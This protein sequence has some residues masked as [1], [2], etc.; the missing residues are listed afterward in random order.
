MD[1]TVMDIRDSFEGSSM[2][3]F[4]EEK[5]LEESVEK[6]FVEAQEQLAQLPPKMQQEIRGI[7]K[8]PAEGGGQRAGG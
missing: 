5:K 1:Q 7:L 6:L 8:R 3:L 2:S 4:G